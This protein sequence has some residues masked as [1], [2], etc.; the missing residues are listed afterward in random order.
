[1]I[2]L[3]KRSYPDLFRGTSKF[4]TLAP[5]SI[6]LSITY[7]IYFRFYRQCHYYCCICR[8]LYSFI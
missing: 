1:V 5:T 3:T 7:H 6:L 8:N 2:V 4:R